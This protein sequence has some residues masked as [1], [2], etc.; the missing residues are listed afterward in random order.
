NG[1]VAYNATAQTVTF[2]PTTGYSGP[3][4]FIY[5]ITDGHS[6]SAS[7]TVSLTVNAGTNSVPVANADK[8]FITAPNTAM[9][10]SAATLLAND[11]DANGDT[12][13]VTSV[14]AA[15][16]GTVSFANNTATFTPTNGYTGAANFTYS[17]ADGKGGTASAQVS[18]TVGNTLWA[19]SNAP[20]LVTANDPGAAELGVKFTASSAG[21][22]NGIRFYKGPQNTGTHVVDLWSSTGTKLATATAANET[23][24]G[25]QQ[26]NFATPISISAGTT[27]IAAYHTDTGFYSADTTYFNAARTTGPLTA[28][29][30]GTS[31]GNGVYIR[32]AGSAFPTSTYQGSNYWVDPIFVASAGGSNSV[33]VANGDKNFITAPNTAM[34]L[35]ATTLL[36]NDTDA[37]GDTLTVTGVS[38]PANGTVTFASN[39]ATFTPTKGYTGT[40]NFTYSISDGKGGTASAQVSLRVANSLWGNSN[41]P[42]LVTANDPGASTLG[43]KFTASAAGTIN[44]IRFYKGPQN[45]G[46]HVVDLW[47]STGTQLATATATSE[48][49]SGW[50]E[51]PFATPV[52]ITAG[53]TYV[54]SYHTNTG[55]Y[56][57]DTNYL[58]S[59]RTSGP[60][61]APSTGTSGGNGV[62]IY[63][64]NDAFP[65]KS[66]QGSNYW[67]DPVFQPQLVS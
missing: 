51:A 34:T 65:N 16:N 48:T 3:A 33:P 47:S 31:G 14:S 35:S 30:T 5:A 61:T 52:S 53:T 4:S 10:V 50:Q 39:T 1:T 43:V 60:L 38:A 6:N 12:L 56:S 22:I 18:L 67:V 23:G 26:A 46:T 36:A 63:G 41:V 42:T 32:S 58:N 62:Y 66:F 13:T 55:F 20:T 17:I 59:A 7:A 29:S 15:A 44:G 28:P 27:Y 64:A 19:N 45:T 25:W 21:T 54:A 37:N 2:T 8:N 40:A 24:S 49:A 9:T 57:A 11:T